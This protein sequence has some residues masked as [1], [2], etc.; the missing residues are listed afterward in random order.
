MAEA[1][2]IDDNRTTAD[3]LGQMLNV[4]GFKARVAYGSGAAMS[5]LAGGLAPKFICL[6]INMPGVDG[7][8]ILAYLRREP[9]LIP[10]PVFV[11]TSDDQPE[12]RR[13]VMKLGANVMIIKPATID[14]LEDALKKVKFLK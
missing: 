6:D 2:I 4:L 7:I 12:T 8:E 13:K 10:V 5:I 3:A 14:A 1:L 9:R 11:I